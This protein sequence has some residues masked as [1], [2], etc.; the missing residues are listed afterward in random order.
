MV[1]GKN[2]FDIKKTDFHKL[3]NL[4]VDELLATVREPKSTTNHVNTFSC[5]Y[6]LMKNSSARGE[7]ESCHS[8]VQ[9]IQC[10]EYSKQQKSIA[11]D[12]LRGKILSISNEC[13][14]KVKRDKRLNNEFFA[15][16][17]KCI[18]I[19]QN[20]FDKYIKY[21]D[22]SISSYYDAQQ[23]AIDENGRHSITY[24]TPSKPSGK[25]KPTF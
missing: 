4:Y 20:L 12:N 9:K 15:K 19:E 14:L 16:I 17:I 3:V 13:L 7:V 5:L 8:L 10:G 25:T 6:E 24:D 22:M 21:S 2:A 11:A 18:V 23:K 1:N